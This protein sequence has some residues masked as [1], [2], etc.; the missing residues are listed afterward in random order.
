MG[1]CTQCLGASAAGEDASA[2]SVLCILERSRDALRFPA[3]L[4]CM[5]AWTSG[6]ERGCAAK[7]VLSRAAAEADRGGGLAGGRGRFLTGTAGAGAFTR[8]EVG[9]TGA[10]GFAICAWHALTSAST[11]KSA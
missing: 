9:M 5:I 6:A 1:I 4:S 11:S 7:C 3:M 8:L 2:A 10:D